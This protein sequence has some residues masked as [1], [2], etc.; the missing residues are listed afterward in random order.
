M[1]QKISAVVLNYKNLKDTVNCLKHLTS[2]DRGKEID[3]YVVDNSPERSTQGI[4]KENFPR[5]T[6]IPSKR[7]LGFAGGNNLAIKRALASGSTHILIINPD[8]T[9]D[10]HFFV[11]LMKHFTDKKVGLVAPVI[12]HTQKGNKIYGL[13]GKVDWTLGKPE[14]RNLPALKDTAPILSQFVS[15]AC[16]LINRETFEKVGLLDEKYFMYFEDVDFC[17]S[18]GKAGFKIILDPKVVVSHRTSSSFKHPTQKLLISFRS[19]LRFIR[20]WLPPARRF[21]P[22]LYAILLYP[23][24]YA[25]WTYHGIKYKHGE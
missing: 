3:C 5:L 22:Y 2:S 12:Y 7:N 20:K 1:R 9:V 14:H 8:V 4:L 15:F 13:E 24:L 6:Y 18:A 16:V 19:H 21:V 10:K 17:L 11:P 25:L 23:Y